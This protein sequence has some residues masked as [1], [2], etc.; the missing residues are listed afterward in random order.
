MAH[1]QEMKWEEEE[2][3]F[4]FVWL[5]LSLASVKALN[6]IEKNRILSQ[7]IALAIDDL[8]NNS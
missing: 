5:M 4:D 2:F 8:V 6:Q 1:L 3:C 7:L